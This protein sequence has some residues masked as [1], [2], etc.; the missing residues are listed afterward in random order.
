[1]EINGLTIYKR[2]H[3]CPMRNELIIQRANI[4]AFCVMKKPVTILSL[5]SFSSS[6]SSSLLLSNPK[7]AL[8]VAIEFWQ[9]PRHPNSLFQ[10]SYFVTISGYIIEAIIIIGRQ[11]LYLVTKQTQ[12]TSVVMSKMCINLWTRFSHFL[13]L[14]SLSSA[15]EPKESSS[16]TSVTPESCLK[17]LSF[18]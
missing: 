2:V 7:I 4:A 10:I 9:K 1:M 17:L 3:A 6:E 11:I 12:R 13:R 16:P 5:S 8:I 15:R 18:A 14:Y